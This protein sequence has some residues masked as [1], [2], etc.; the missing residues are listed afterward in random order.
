MMILDA[1]PATHSTTNECTFLFVSDADHPA[2]QCMNL[3]A[4]FVRN[5]GALFDYYDREPARVGGSVPHATL[6]IT[7]GGADSVGL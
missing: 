6:S 5:L 7:S 3:F 1:S 2:D 4:K